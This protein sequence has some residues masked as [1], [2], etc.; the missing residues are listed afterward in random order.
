MAI[1]T[2][3]VGN[4]A[5]EAIEALAARYEDVEDVEIGG[6]QLIVAFKNIPHDD[7]PGTEILTY[8]ED[9]DVVSSLGLAV[10]ALASMF[11][12]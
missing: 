3:R 5:L 7:G 10:G 8:T 6:L 9:D 12:R 4:F 2:R 11:D 1:D